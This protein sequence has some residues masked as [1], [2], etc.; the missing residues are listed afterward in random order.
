MKYRDLIHF[1]PIQT[2]KVLREADEIE[3]AKEDVTTFVFSDRLVAELGDRRATSGRE[4]GA[5]R[6][7]E[8][9]NRQ[10]APHGRHLSA[11]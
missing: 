7:C 8:L 9:R 5:L 4:Q 2:V 3:H 11:R 6:C 1:E 10:D